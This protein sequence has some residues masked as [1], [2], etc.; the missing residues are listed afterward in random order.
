MFSSQLQKVMFY[1][2]AGL[3]IEAVAVKPRGAAS[4]ADL[5]GS[6]TYFHEN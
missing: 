3:R 5:G 2:F 4:C 1:M 6:S